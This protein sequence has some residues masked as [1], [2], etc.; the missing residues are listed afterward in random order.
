MGGSKQSRDD[1]KTKKELIAEVEELRRKVSEDKTAAQSGKSGEPTL[2]ADISRRDALKI[3][4]VAPVILSVPLATIGLARK[5]QAGTLPP[6]KAPTAAMEPTLAPTAFPAARAVPA[7][8]AGVAAAAAAALF[9]FGVNKLHN[10]I[11]GEPEGDDPSSPKDESDNG[12][13]SS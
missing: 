1:H 8:S 6:T 10:K 5:A 9:G 4:W 12:D 13:E 2:T 11:S 7:V 3:A